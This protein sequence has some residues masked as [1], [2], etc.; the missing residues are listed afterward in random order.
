MSEDP[1]IAPAVNPELLRAIVSAQSM[2]QAHTVHQE[3][4]ASVGASEDDIFE[5]FKAYLKKKDA[6]WRSKKWWFGVA[7]PNVLTTV[8]QVATGAI[9]WQG[10]AIGLAATGIGYAIAQGGVD[11]ARAQALGAATVQAMAAKLAKKG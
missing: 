8:V 5:S 3:I 6:F 11:K 7:I 4:V 1:K 9:S 10:V 2:A